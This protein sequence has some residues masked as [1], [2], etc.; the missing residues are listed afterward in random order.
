MNTRAFQIKNRE[1][2]FRSTRALRCFTFQFSLV[3]QLRI[4]TGRLLMIQVSYSINIPDF[5]TFPQE[6]WGLLLHNEAAQW[7]TESAD[8]ITQ[9]LLRHRFA[10]YWTKG[11]RCKPTTSAIHQ[12]IGGP[13]GFS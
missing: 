11:P 1:D 10:V 5:P 9:C 13:E 8:R 7:A 6:L 3:F 12:S 2:D 4:S